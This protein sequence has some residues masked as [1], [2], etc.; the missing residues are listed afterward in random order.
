[1][2]SLR[3]NLNSVDDQ[4]IEPNEHYE[5]V[6]HVIDSIYHRCGQACYSMCGEDVVL[7]LGCYPVHLGNHFENETEKPSQKCL[8]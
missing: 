6:G 4:K 7:S 2:N 5:E 8:V 1:M 3:R